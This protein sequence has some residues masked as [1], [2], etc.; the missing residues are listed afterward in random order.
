MLMQQKML[1]DCRQ[2]AEGAGWNIFEYDPKMFKPFAVNM[3]R[4]TLRWRARFFFEFLTGYTVYYLSVDNMLAGYCVLARGGSKRYG[5]SSASDIL[6]GP[7]FIDEAFRGRRLSTL[8]L[9]ETLALRC[10]DFQ[11]AFAY[12]RKSNAPSLAAFQ[13]AGFARYRDA[14]VS[15]IL[16]RVTETEDGRYTLMK[17]EGMPDGQGERRHSNL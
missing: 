14:A 3:E 5:F 13:S 1:K 11:N 6:I 12:I 2:V 9:R 16:R 7:I 17:L 8:L 4:L 10:G 15:L